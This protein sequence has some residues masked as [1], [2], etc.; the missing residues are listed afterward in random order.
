MALLILALL[1]IVA[2][3]TV[4]WVAHH[5]RRELLRRRQV[6]RVRAAL[7]APGRISVAELRAR[8]GA[9]GLKRYPTPGRAA[10][11]PDPTALPGS[12]RRVA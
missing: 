5:V 11:V 6:A 10:G 1:G 4:G 8:C 2:A 12:T 7:A 3:G 9:D